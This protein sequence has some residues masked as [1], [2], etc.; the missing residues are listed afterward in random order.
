MAKNNQRDFYDYIIFN[1]AFI[2]YYTFHKTIK[3]KNGL[4]ILIIY[5]MNFIQFT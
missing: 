2:S 4:S 5:Y 3:N 1:D